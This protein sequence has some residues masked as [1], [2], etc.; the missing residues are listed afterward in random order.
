L[1]SRVLIRRRQHPGRQGLIR[2]V[3]TAAPRKARLDPWLDTVRRYGV[4]WRLCRV[5]D[6]IY[7]DLSEIERLAG[8]PTIVI[9]NHLC[10][11]DGV[12]MMVVAHKLGRRLSVA[13]A[14]S[15]MSQRPWLQLLG[16]FA[17]RRGDPR[18]TADQL[19]EIGRRTAAN[20][21]SMLCFFPEG[22][23][24]RSGLPVEPERGVLAVAVGAGSIP[25]VPIA[26]RYEFFERP[27]PTVWVSA[28]P[29]VT[30]REARRLG[31]RTVLDEAQAA[32]DERLR[33]GGGRFVPL[34]RRGQG[35]ILLENVPCS[36]SRL[37]RGLR[38]E[39]L[40]VSALRPDA[41]PIAADRA[42]RAARAVGL[43][44]GPLYR[45]LVLRA[46]TKGD[47]NGGT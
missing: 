16:L 24:V 5:F 40:E 34:L 25:L 18:T 28:A 11:Q 15:V 13:T 9:P 30:A 38:S 14:E 22:A 47:Q 1:S 12:V 31:L 35:T 45:E 26:L 20:P 7:A 27:R 17:V 29:A 39:G 44:A 6:E 4:G 32:L 19:M 42:E 21:A 41:G 46:L 37:E 43:T 36:V 10:A 2:R 23:H 8:S 33:H 3:C